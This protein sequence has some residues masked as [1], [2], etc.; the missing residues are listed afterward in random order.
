MNTPE[1]FATAAI[2]YLKFRRRYQIAS[3][4]FWV[5]YFSLIPDSITISNLTDLRSLYAWTLL[6]I[7]A[8][9]G[10]SLWLRRRYRKLADE[11]LP[12]IEAKTLV[13]Q[14][15]AVKNLAAFIEHH[16][17]SFRNACLKNMRNAASFIDGWSIGNL[18]FL[19]KQFGDKMEY[20][21]KAFRLRLIPAIEGS[22]ANSDTARRIHQ[23]LAVSTQ[24]QLLS[25]F[26]GPR[27]DGWNNFL[28]SFKQVEPRG[29]W[30]GLVSRAVM[31]NVAYLL[32]VTTVGYSYFVVQRSILGADVNTA[33][34]GVNV[35][36]GILLTPYAVHLFSR[37]QSRKGPKA[38]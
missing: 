36:L 9:V 6:S 34:T 31:Y 20:F 38:H 24:N 1:T 19:E 28:G 8:L 22:E 4:F 18:Q 29:I 30:R 37:Y 14:Q 16:S 23:F 12:T 17:K 5:S 13:F 21:K 26:D 3:W 2:Q 25:G 15:L 27:L 7:L 32:F 35:I 10:I 33:T 11:I